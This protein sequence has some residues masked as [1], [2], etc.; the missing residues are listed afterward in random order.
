M[1]AA[2]HRFHRRQRRAYSNTVGRPCLVLSAIGVVVFGIGL[3]IK[4]AVIRGVL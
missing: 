4:I 3:E 1:A 2:L